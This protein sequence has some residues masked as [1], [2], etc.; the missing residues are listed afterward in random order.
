MY[1]CWLTNWIELGIQQVWK[2]GKDYILKQ[3]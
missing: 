3:W 2:L 1:K